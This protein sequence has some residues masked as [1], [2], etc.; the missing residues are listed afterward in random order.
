MHW[1]TKWLG[2][3]YAPLGRGPEVYDCL[4][5]FLAIQAEEFG[6]ALDYGLVPLGPAEESARQRHIV[7]E[8]HKVDEAREG[9]MILMR[10]GGGWHVGTA[11]NNTQMLHATQPASAI[12]AF[13]TGKWGRR[14]S[15]DGPQGVYRYND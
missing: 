8:W 10:R 14:L 4:G 15:G 7:P 3:P 1:T 2:K 13:R 5:L 9:D 11:L 12:E 6:R